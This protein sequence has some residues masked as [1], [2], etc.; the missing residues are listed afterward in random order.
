MF[1]NNPIREVVLFFTLTL[2]LSY[3]VFWGPLAFFKIPTISFVSDIKGPIW[4]I[5]LYLLGGFVP[6]LTAIVMT[7]ILEGTAGLKHLGRRLIQFRIGWQWYFATIALVVAGTAGQL[8][9]IKLLGQEFNNSLFIQQLG[10]ALPLLITGPLS[11][12]IGWRGFALDRLQKKLNPLFSSLIIGLV[13]GLWHLPLF[14][15]IG[16]SQHELAIPFISFAAGLISVSVLYTWLYNNTKKSI[17]TAVFFHWIFTYS[18]QVVASGVT[19]SAIYN[20]LEGIPYLLIT[21]IVI[22]V[23]KNQLLR[24]NSEEG[25]A[26]R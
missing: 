16:T 4:A 19:R 2:G 6:S 11:E 13:W 22:L 21:I 25:N 8:V 9:I 1:R 20:W 23:W 18:M 12:E 24:M 17:W 15:M 14:G 7:W 10:S 3:F 26:C 5:V